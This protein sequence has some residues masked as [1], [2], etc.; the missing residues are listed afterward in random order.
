MEDQVL[1]PVPSLPRL[2]EPAPDFEADSTVGRIRLSD[3]RGKWV[4]MYSHPADFTPVCT[5]EFMAFSRRKAEFDAL[6]TQLLGL[7]IDSVFSH[8]AWVNAI[9]EKFGEHTPFPIIADLDMHVSRLYGMI[10]PKAATTQAVRALFIIDPQG[11]LRLMIYYP[12]TTGRN[13]DEVLRVLKSLQ[14]VD[15]YQVNTGANWQPG[16]PVIVSPPKTVEG[17]EERRG[18]AGLECKDW[19]FCTRKL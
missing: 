9:R 3:F 8:L 12:M 17:L 7:S 19:Y 4:V 11:I 10:H 18:E 15:Q 2:N 5:T 16:D 1:E 13:I 6:N 14:T